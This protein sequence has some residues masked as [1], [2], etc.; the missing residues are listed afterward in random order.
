MLTVHRPFPWLPR[1]ES[2]IIERNHIIGNPVWMLRALLELTGVTDIDEG[3]FKSLSKRF[4]DKRLDIDTKAS[5][6]R[7]CEEVCS[8]FNIIL[9]C[10]NGT[11]KVK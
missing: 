8:H 9:L 5:L 3:S 1:G 4:G 2:V 6:H 7:L 10:D 11:F